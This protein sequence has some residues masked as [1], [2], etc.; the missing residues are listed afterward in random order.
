MR[1]KT[2]FTATA[3]AS[4]LFAGTAFAETNAR[5]IPAVSGSA[6]SVPVIPSGY[7]FQL[8]GGVTGFTRQETRD[9]FGAGAYWDARAIF[10]TRSYLGAELAYV[11]SARKAAAS[12]LTGT[13][14]LLGNGAEAA[15]RA[16]LPLDLGAMRLTPFAFGGVGWTHYQMVNETGN[17]SIIKDKANALTLPFGA[18]LSATYD[19]FVLDARFTYRPMFDDKLVNVKT[20]SRDHA[21]LQNW[22]AGLTLG[23]EI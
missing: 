13:P 9:K 1:T 2:I 5:E 14:Q 20:G 16:N 6:S 11:G 19:H 7:A 15:L 12:G 4:S 8:G 10:G 23:Y 17:A 21:D 18:G 3:I 22:A